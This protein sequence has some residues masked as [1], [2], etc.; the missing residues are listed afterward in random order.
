MYDDMMIGRYSNGSDIEFV[1][2]IPKIGMFSVVQ[3][4]CPFN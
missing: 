3:K 2:G 4:A 1:P